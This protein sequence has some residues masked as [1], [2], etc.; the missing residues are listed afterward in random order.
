MD[1]SYRLADMR[2]ARRSLDALAG[3]L[4]PAHAVALRLAGDG[5]SESEIAAALGIPLESVAPLLEI[6]H[7]KLIG[8]AAR[9]REDT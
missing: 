5:A 1:G 6:G 7:A 4:A 3:Q 9:R 2:R 8:L